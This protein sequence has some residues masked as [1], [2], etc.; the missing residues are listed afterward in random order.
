MRL[1]SPTINRTDN[2]LR[3]FV[4]VHLSEVPA[5]SVRIE[6][7][8]DAEGEH[9]SESWRLVVRTATRHQIPYRRSRPSNR[10]GRESVKAGDVVP[11]TWQEHET[12][13]ASVIPAD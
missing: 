10:A 8:A 3:A 9:A 2:A 12:E 13:R 11:L 5:S 7:F 6:L 1:G 4:P